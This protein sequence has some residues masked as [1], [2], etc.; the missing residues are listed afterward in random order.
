MNG[1]VTYILPPR[2]APRVGNERLLFSGHLCQNTVCEHI[3]VHF[4]RCDLPFE[5][6]R[7]MGEVSFLFTKE[8]NRLQAALTQVQYV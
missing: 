2:Y 1:F 7:A 5:T 8:Y 3:C 6:Q 4:Y